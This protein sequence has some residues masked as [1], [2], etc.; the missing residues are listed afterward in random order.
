MILIISTTHWLSC[1]DLFVSRVMFSSLVLGSDPVVFC[2]SCRSRSSAYF[3][4]GVYL[5]CCDYSIAHFLWNYNHQNI[6]NLQNI[7]VNKREKIQIDENLLQSAKEC[8]IM[9]FVV[10]SLAVACLPLPYTACFYEA[11]DT[12]Q[13]RATGFF[14]VNFL[15]PTGLLRI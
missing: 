10:V 3:A 11:G 8:A 9:V 2:W 14:S 12:Q 1:S 13:G 5:L 7:F 15:H 4:I 6:R